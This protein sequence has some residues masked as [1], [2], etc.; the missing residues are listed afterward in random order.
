MNAFKIFG[1]AIW[2]AVALLIVGVGIWSWKS[3]KAIGFFAGVEPPKVKDVQK[4]NR[5]VGCLWFVYAALFELLGFPFLFQ[6][7]NS[8]LFIVTVLG[9]VWITILLVVVYHRILRKYRQD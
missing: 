9:V 7:Q 3:T 8:P 4:Y 6:K 1:L 5:A 2:S